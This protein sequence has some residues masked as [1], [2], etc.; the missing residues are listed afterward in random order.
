MA[1][2]R[3]GPTAAALVLACTAG[4][5]TGCGG[6]GNEPEVQ[7]EESSSPTLAP[8]QQTPTTT[9]S[10]SA[11]PVDAEAACVNAERRAARN[12]WLWKAVG[13]VT[14]APSGYSDK[15]RSTVVNHTGRARERLAEECGGHA[16]S[17]F[18]QFSTDIQPA[19]A[20][21]RFGNP[22]L[23]KVLAAWLRWG[24]AV[25]APDTARQ[26]MRDLG[27]CRREFFP[28]FDASYRIW[29]KWTETGKAWWVD[30]EFAN[31]TGRVLDG[32]MDGMARASKMLP[33]PFGWARGPRPG[34]GKDAILHW[35]GSSADV[36]ALQPGETSVRVWPDA[37]Q[38]VHTTAD[39]TFRVIEMAVGLGPRGEP[40]GCSPPVQPMP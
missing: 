5:V 37:D 36:L 4:L 32:S 18:E 19:V 39:G 15:A 16:P 17:A 26:E 21:E 27:F 6:E 31:R 34:P 20:A 3:L 28:R 13:E 9:E 29:W 14:G 1:A 8:E 23:D 12:I 24:S 25:G 33:D 30:I 11:A 35:G 22:Q 2:C 10:P 38:D 40:Y 7:V